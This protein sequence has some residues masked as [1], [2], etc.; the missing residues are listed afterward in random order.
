MYFF[1]QRLYQI[2]ELSIKSL[3]IC[4]N[5]LKATGN[6][7]KTS[8]KFC[9]YGSLW[10]DKLAKPSESACN[11]DSIPGSGRSPGERNGNPLQYSCLENSKDKRTWWATVHGITMSWTRLC[12]F[13]FHFQHNWHNLVA[14]MAKDLPTMWETCL[15]PWVRK[16]CQRREWQ[17]TP[18]FLS[19]ESQG[20]RSLVG[21]GP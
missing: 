19:G 6:N 21:Y 7:P 14:Q 3:A 18:V 9:Q 17:A 8:L 15:D 10:R 20:Q 5:I 12:D 2:L 11:A 4:I 16:I 13:H 1:T